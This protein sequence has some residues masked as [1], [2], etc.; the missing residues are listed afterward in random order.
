MGD[1]LLAKQIN[2]KQHAREYWIN[3]DLDAWDFA[4][5]T[6]RDIKDLGPWV[7]VREVVPGSVTITREEFRAAIAKFDYGWDGIDV[8]SVEDEL[9]GKLK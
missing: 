1:T 7:H 4:P 5:D 6:E 3:A 2:D 8:D 9:F